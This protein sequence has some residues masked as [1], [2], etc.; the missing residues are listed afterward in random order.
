MMQYDLI[1]DNEKNKTYRLWIEQ[2]ARALTDTIYRLADPN[3]TNKNN[4]L[5]VAQRIELLKN[6]LSVFEIIY[7]KN[8]LSVNREFYEI[9]RVIGCLYLLDKQYESALEHFEK[10]SDYA[11]AFD[12]YKDGTLYSS[13]MI[14]GIVTDNHNLWDKS[15]S[16]DMLERLTKQTRYDVLKDNARY[17]SIIAKLSKT[18]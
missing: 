9:N 16:A 7:G 11:V 4:D 8:L 12:A 18:L 15:A 2:Y 10:A 1:D 5:Y 6:L 17:K 14:C 13:L 3:Y